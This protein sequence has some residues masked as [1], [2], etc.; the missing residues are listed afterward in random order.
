MPQF[1]DQES[2]E[3]FICRKCLFNESIL[4]TNCRE[5]KKCFMGDSVQSAMCTLQEN[6]LVSLFESSLYAPLSKKIS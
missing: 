5:I 4:A 6:E 2:T 1:N 3:V